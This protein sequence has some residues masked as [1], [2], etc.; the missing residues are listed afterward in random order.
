MNK[1]VKPECGAA[2]QQIPE[3]SSWQQYNMVLFRKDVL[4]SE[5]SESSLHDSSVSEPTESQE[6]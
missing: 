3:T 6:T 1:I 5:K 2:G 4:Y